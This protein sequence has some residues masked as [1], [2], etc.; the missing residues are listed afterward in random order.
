[1]SAFE[2]TV[3]GLV[4]GIGFISFVKEY[5]EKNH[6]SGNIKNSGGVVRI[7]VECDEVEIGK[8]TYNLRY[9]CPEGGRVESILVKPVEE[10]YVDE[11]AH[12]MS[13]E[14]QAVADKVDAAERDDD[15]YLARIRNDRYSSHKN[16]G[17]HESA[18]S[19][20]E[21][22]KPEDSRNKDSESAD[23]RPVD[24]EYKENV[25][26]NSDKSSDKNSRDNSEEKSN[27]NS[28]QKK[29]EDKPEAIDE[30]GIMT[31]GIVLDEFGRELDDSFR[32]IKSDTYDEEVRFLPTD[33]AICKDCREEL[34]DPEN[35]RYRYP[36]ISCTKCGPRYSIMRAVPYERENTSMVA[37]NMCTEC[38]REY[39][40][41]GSRRR[42]DQNMGCPECGPKLR[43]YE[44]R[45][46]DEVQMTQEEMLDH[47]INSL[48]DGKIGAI[49][50]MGGFQFFC[51]PTSERTVERLR[52]FKDSANKP[53]SLMF[54]DIE[55]IKKY[56]YVSD[57]EEELLQSNARPIVLLDRR[58]ELEEGLPKIADSVL[59]GS[60]RIGAALPFDPLQTILTNEIGVLVFTSGNRFGDPIIIN[61]LDMIL[62]LPRVEGS[63]VSLNLQSVVAFADD[64][65]D[66]DETTY[67]GNVN[68]N[69][70]P[71]IDFMLTNTREVLAPL[72]DSVAQMSRIHPAK[73]TRKVVQLVRRGR[74][75]VPQPIMLENELV[76]N[77]FAGGTDY[78]SS[79]ALG[80]K[81]AVYLSEYYGNMTN[82]LVA[83]VRAKAIERMENLLG[84]SPTRFLGDM[85]PGYFSV[86]DADNRALQVYLD[87]I[88]QRV[89]KRQHHAS[90]VLSVAAEHGLTGRLL[91]V[92]FDGTG[93]GLDETTW[94]SEIFSCVI[95]TGDEEQ[96]E[97][98]EKEKDTS[99]V[100]AVPETRAKII[101]AGALL[102]VK[103]MGGE[104]SNRDIRTTLCGYIRSV[105]ER[106][107]VSH[108]TVEKVLKILNIDK[109]DYGII[110]ACLR[111]DIN[112][113]YSACMGRLFDAVAAL[114]G[115]K[116]KNTFGGESPIA[117]ECAAMKYFRRHRYTMKDIELLDLKLGVIEPL[118]EEDVYRM[119]QAT[120]IADLMEKVVKVHETCI[121]EDEYTAAIEELAFEFHKAIVDST[122]YICDKVCG[123]DYIQH[124]ALTGGSMYNRLLL[125]GIASNLERLGYRTFINT[126]VP[127]GDGGI[128][129]GQMFSEIMI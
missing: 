42:F 124:I 22:S 59:K 99:K 32:V 20:A 9:N 57:V 110:S 91:G 6:L 46:I 103:L 70:E 60:T 114:L 69:E 80:K 44:N 14:L 12:K 95:S 104:Q 43:Y 64:T 21:E 19:T 58:E 65:L 108:S 82:P 49:K 71:C 8:F 76:K 100:D 1:M 127:C 4:Q 88:P 119:D 5:A 102:P 120:L 33:I 129:L 24:S 84:I 3:T 85:N 15:D 25:D 90:H 109:N 89:Q 107:L 39:D 62:N 78:E 31:E 61:D 81:N 118:D 28:N 26:N 13:L 40:E 126:R 75:Y 117:L 96:A 56:C 113:Y 17:D 37:F 45:M 11:E 105:E 73:V 2:I 125:D 50:G 29:T 34:L 48:K 86:K 16:A 35:R 63:T 97:K 18:D 111:A 92:A 53:F 122:V 98:K 79:F 66:K 10:E 38:A 30:N 23:S 68:E 74:G 123:R 36:F 93:Y 47:T 121:M 41:P 101:R 83:D 52:E 67:I 87:G 7:Y 116:T 55:T 51:I 72:E 54:P 94:G 112:I 77:T 115:L 106:Q 27:N 128:S